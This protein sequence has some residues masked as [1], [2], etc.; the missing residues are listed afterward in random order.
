LAVVCGVCGPDGVHE[1][2][3]GLVE[4][5]GCDGGLACGVHVDVEPGEDRFI[6]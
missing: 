4:I 6:E 3:E 2:A 1:A 5:V